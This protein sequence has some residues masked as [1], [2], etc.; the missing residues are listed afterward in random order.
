[1]VSGLCGWIG[2]SQSGQYWVPSLTKSEAQEV[3]DLGERAHRAL[4]AAAAGAL[5][6]RH[7]GRDAEDGVH[8]RA[9]RRR[10][11]KLP[12][13]GVERFQVAALALG[14]QDVEGQRGL[15]RCPRRR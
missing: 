11:H 14:K 13:I 1:M 2:T 5:L 3:M 8:V 9:A 15:A 7:R 12:R 4:P 10:L 6:D